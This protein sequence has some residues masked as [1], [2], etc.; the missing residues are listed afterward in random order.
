MTTT[1]G[2]ELDG[3]TISSSS[4]KLRENTNQSTEKLS[5]GASKMQEEEIFQI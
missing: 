2:V 1:D 4:S 3:E 5:T